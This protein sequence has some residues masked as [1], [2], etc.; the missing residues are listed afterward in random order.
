M[1]VECLRR[2]LGEG[3]LYCVE[4]DCFTRNIICENTPKNP[5]VIILSNAILAPK[6]D[7]RLWVL[8][9]LRNRPK[10]QCKNLE[11][12]HIMD[13]SFNTYQV[14][15]KIPMRDSFKQLPLNMSRQSIRRRVKSLPN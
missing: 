13:I 5:E 15:A 11:T 12:V 4:S 2:F 3:G 7:F 1:S 9:A 14:Y 10:R 6:S 8:N